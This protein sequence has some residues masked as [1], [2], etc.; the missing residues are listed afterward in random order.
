MLNCGPDVLVELLDNGTD[1]DAAVVPELMTALE[2]AAY[3]QRIDLLRV[4]LQRGASADHVG[5]RG[6]NAF[7]Y[8]FYPDERNWQ[9]TPTMDTVNVLNEYVWMDPSAT[10]DYGG[11]A[12][13]A[14]AMFSLDVD[15]DALVRLGC[16]LDHVDKQGSTALRYAVKYGNSSAYFGLLRNGAKIGGDGKGKDR[17]SALLMNAIACKATVRVP[18]DGFMEFDHETIVKHLLR[19][20]LP[21]DSLL[22]IHGNERWSDGESWPASITDRTITWREFAAAYGPEAEDWLAG[23][24]RDCGWSAYAERQYAC[25][26]SNKMTSSEGLRKGHVIGE[27]A[28]EAQQRNDV[29]AAQAYRDD[30]DS[31][32]QCVDSA[33]DDRDDNDEGER[34]W[35]AVE[36]LI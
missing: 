1:I 16:D 5:A 25:G 10:W 30:D 3:R 21:A 29:Q 24:L 32:E 12:L 6:L 34:F 15:I 19:R 2:F 28:A 26:G 11:T 4:L 7:F 36:T 8:S 20:H 17:A 13:H 31:R 14:A 23:I 18:S 33:I 22:Y 27:V 9:K 35:D